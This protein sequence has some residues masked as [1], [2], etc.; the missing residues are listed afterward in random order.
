MDGN[1]ETRNETAVYNFEEVI[2]SANG[3]A[4]TMDIGDFI[5]YQSKLSRA[6]TTN[7]SLL[8]NVV[9]ES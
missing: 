5:S 9:V 4:V 2:S 6:S 1:S 3:V 7:Y 8:E